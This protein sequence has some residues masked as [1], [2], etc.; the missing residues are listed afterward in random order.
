MAGFEVSL[1]GFSE[2]VSQDRLMLR[3]ECRQT[4]AALNGNSQADD[5]GSANRQRTRDRY[6]QSPNQQLESPERELHPSVS[7]RLIRPV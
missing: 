1:V 2:E 6:L 3:W 4:A 5:H 7:P